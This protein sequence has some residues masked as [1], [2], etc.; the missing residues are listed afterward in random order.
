VQRHPS[1]FQQ[2]TAAGHKVGNHTF[3]H[4]NGWRTAAETYIQDVDECRK[5]V[6]SGL[7]RPPYGRLTRT[8]SRLLL[9][10]NYRIVAWDVLSGDFDPHRSPE[11][12][13]AGIVRHAGPGSI[14]VLH[15]SLKAFPRLEYVL[16]RVLAHFSALGY[17]FEAL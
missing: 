4:L 2:L 8:Q 5:V 10:R 16:P 13:L 14:I 17:R 1:V 15:D 9:E 12:C 6:D 7:F 3:H 11:A